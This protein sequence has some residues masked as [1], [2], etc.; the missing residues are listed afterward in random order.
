[1]R[2]LARGNWMDESGEIVTPGAP[3]FLHQ[4]RKERRANRKD[5]ADWIT[6]RENPLTARV[7]V[8]RLWKS[9][10][11]G[12]ISKVLDDLGTQGETPTHPEL[13]DT[14]AIEFTDSG[15]NIKHLVRLIVMS[16]AYRQS[17]LMRDEL[18]DVDPYNR[19]LARQSRFRLDAE[20][21][22][23]N[24][25]AVS[26][27]LIRKT[28][29][30]SVKPYQPA[31]LYR[32]LNFPARKYKHDAGE[33][34]Y[35][36]GVYTHWQRQFLHPA[37]KAFDAPPREECTAERPRSNTPLAA[38]VLLNDPSYVEAARVFAAKVIKHGGK[39]TQQRIKW[40]MQHA[41]SRNP[42]QQEVRILSGLLSAQIEQY[43]QQ[44][45][46]AQKLASTGL[47]DVPKDTDVTELAAWTSVTR[48][49]F[50]MH[51]FITRN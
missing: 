23:D 21:I 4:I 2:V 45:A 35:R 42:N 3:H 6:A 31:G 27:L 16:A 22:R 51:E 36:R 47:S 5:L 49:V 14:L 48:T 9:Y 33:N 46:E 26:G 10:F 40:M 41:L 17:S 24:A 19:L 13:L 12:G 28:G 43:K 18:R 38:L 25:L 20:I 11:D 29:G 32:H 15:W 37:M 7:F 39:D 34:Q 1:M 8:N 30:R 44:P 50:N